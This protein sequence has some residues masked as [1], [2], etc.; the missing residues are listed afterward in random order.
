MKLSTPLAKK[1]G[2]KY[3]FASAPMFII[4]NKEMIVAAAEAGILGCMPSLN[5]RTP[6][7]LREDLAWIRQ[8]TDKAFGINITIG[9]TAPERVEAD[10]A[11]CIEFEVPVILTSYGNPTALVKQAHEHKRLVFH[12]VINLA[13]GKKAVAAGADGIIAVSAGAGGHAGR[14]SPYVLIPW[15]KEELKVPILAAGCISDGRQVVAS[16]SLGAELCY[17]GTRFI[18]STECG[19]AQDYKD[20]VVKATPEDIVYTDAVS[21]IHANF[22]KHTVP[23][24]FAADRSPDG[25]KRWKDIWSAGQGVGLITQVKSM[26]EIV[27]DLARE[28]HDTLAAFG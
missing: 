25:A 5:A 11:L 16:L 18:A 26:G 14:I 10:M 15:L 13:H 2:L 21:G 4:S 7:K 17:I 27:E 1:L 3:P 8:R 12:D 9:L 22:I 24:N 23:E 19:A 20:S 6:E 28:A